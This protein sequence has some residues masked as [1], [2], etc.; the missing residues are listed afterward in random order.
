MS[1]WAGAQ[2][3][4]P[5]FHIAVDS[6]FQNILPVPNNGIAYY[7]TELIGISSRFL[8]AH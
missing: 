4:D 3:N 7:T 1:I 6:V 5:K 2:L 8:P